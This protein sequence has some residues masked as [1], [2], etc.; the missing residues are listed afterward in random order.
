[1]NHKHKDQNQFIHDAAAEQ[2][3]QQQQSSKRRQKRHIDNDYDDTTSVETEVDL[4]AVLNIPRDADEED[5]KNAYKKLVITYHPDKQ[6]SEEMKIQSQENFSLITLAR[7]ILLDDKLRAI[8]NEF[9]LRGVTDSQSIVKK[10]DNVE[11]LLDAMDRIEKEKS[12]E[13]ILKDFKATGQQSISLAY[14]H[15][16]RYFWFKSLSASQSFSLNS[17]YGA[18]EVNPHITRKNND[19][20]LGISAR[21]RVPVF[22]NKTFIY[23]FEYNENTIPIN[24]VTFHSPLAAN[25]Q[26]T[27][28][29]TTV[30]HYP[31][32]FGGSIKRV[33]SPQVEGI[34]SVVITRVQKSITLDITRTVEKRILNLNL[35]LGTVTGGQATISREIPIGKNTGF[36][37][38]F[39]AYT[40][41]NR[42]ENGLGSVFTTIGTRVN[43]VLDLSFTMKYTPTRYLYIIGIHHR[44]QTLEIPIPIYTDIS[45]LNSLVFFTLPSV[46]LSLFKLLVINPIVKLKENKRIQ[47][48]KEK[49][50][51]ACLEARRKAEI[52]IKLM[53]ST[54][55]K[56]VLQEKA[57]NGLVIQEALYGKLN[58]KA[59]SGADNL[60]FP[61]YI[62]VTVPLQYLVD[63]S[64]L[65][66]HSNKKSDLLGFWDPRIGEE[67]QLKVTY[68]F[69]N[70]LHIVV[71]ND[72]DQLMIP[73]RSHL[74]Q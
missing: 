73:L 63:D 32:M 24:R 42:V 46:T 25:T 66:L 2:D 60:E 1:M 19:A 55:D 12:E 51:S 72:N 64:K 9:G 62:N 17:K 49:F 48:R 4:Y 57:K 6:T 56:K 16:Y 33:F 70:K 61:P 22:Q 23:D 14:M 74:I 45:L 35:Q 58:D 11:N 69:Q 31:V 26:G 30:K 15:S 10:Y 8:Y 20:T 21:Y 38:G 18:F 54:V 53:K 40:G 28:S 7:D 41:F 36:E 29:M 13:K 37:F 3:N 5:I 27:I 43:K 71:V 44:F 65:M 68:F 34:A 59:V 67:K 52:D 47:E 50:A 39:S